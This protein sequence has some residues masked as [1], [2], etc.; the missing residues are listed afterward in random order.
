MGFNEINSKPPEKDTMQMLYL[1]L[2]LLFAGYF[3]YLVWN[4]S[5][6]HPW[7]SGG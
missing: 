6:K 4:D 1:T 2:K 5:V 7:Q 3:F